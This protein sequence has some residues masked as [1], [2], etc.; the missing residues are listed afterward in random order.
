MCLCFPLGDVKLEPWVRRC[1]DLSLIKYISVLGFVRNMRAAPFICR[2]PPLGLLSLAR[3]HHSGSDSH[4]IFSHRTCW[5]WPAPG[6]VVNKVPSCVA[7]QSH[8]PLSG[9]EMRHA[10]FCQSL[11]GGTSPSSSPSWPLSSFWGAWGHFP[12]DV[13][14]DRAPHPTPPQSG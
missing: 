11:A 9:P 8:W 6:L 1:P 7:A 13:S 4:V 14:L 12:R 5:V 10:S 2:V 3:S